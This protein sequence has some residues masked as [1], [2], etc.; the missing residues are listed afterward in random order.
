MMDAIR[1]ESAETN[2]AKSP[3]QSIDRTVALLEAIAAAGPAGAPLSSVTATAGVHASTGRTLLTAL[4][5]HGLVAQID[6]TRRYVLGPRFFELNRTY[7]LQ[8]DLGAV[9]APILRGLWEHSNET[10]HLA[11]L[12][13]G[14]RVDI[15]VLVSP[16]LLNI[17]PSAMRASASPIHPL[18]HT[19]AGKVLLAGMPGDERD[20]IL[21][22]ASAEADRAEIDQ[23][24]ATVLGAG[25]ATNH[26]EEVAGVCGI[27][28]PVRDHNGRT[29][30]AM[31]VGYPTARQSGEYEARLRESTVEAA[32]ELSRMLGAPLE[33]ETGESA[34]A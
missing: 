23:E 9:A 12:Q 10:V 32:A 16:Q 29:V 24:L 5:V 1:D 19:A 25:F 13:H 33:A 6:S 22:S 2:V 18:L 17:N 4:M 21:D 3:I 20:R 26:E 11:T 8:H 34:D 27:A 15:A 7:T 28:A 14:R 30:A 31:C